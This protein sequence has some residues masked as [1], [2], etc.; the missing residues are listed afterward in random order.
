MF[1]IRFSIPSLTNCVIIQQ[2]ANINQII[3]YVNEIVM[4]SMIN[5]LLTIWKQII[6]RNINNFG[7][8]RIARPFV[9]ESWSVILLPIVPIVPLLFLAKICVTPFTC[10]PIM[11]TT[12]KVHLK[13]QNM[14]VQIFLSTISTLNISFKTQSMMT[15]C[16]MQQKEKKTHEKQTLCSW[17][18]SFTSC[19][20][21][22]HLIFS[23]SSLHGCLRLF[24]V[25]L[26]LLYCINFFV[27][28]LL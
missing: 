20:I 10:Y 22:E 19:S 12:P 28:L 18:K 13:L 8:V 2:R 7:Y 15:W 14:H 11:S 4:G 21:F 26:S 1:I 5:V 16:E 23:R 3:S 6:V 17:K 9:K 27:M 25:F 24:L